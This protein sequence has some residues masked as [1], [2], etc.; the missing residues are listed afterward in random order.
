MN[1]RVANAGAMSERLKTPH[2]VAVELLKDLRLEG[3]K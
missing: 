2:Q 3:D 1:L